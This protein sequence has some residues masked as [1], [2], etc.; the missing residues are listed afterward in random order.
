MFFDGRRIVYL[1][2]YEDSQKGVS[3]G[4]ARFLKE[5]N[6][7]KLEVNLSKVSGWKDGEYQIFLKG[8]DRDICLGFIRITEGKGTALRELSVKKDKLCYRTDEEEADKLYG[9]AVC[10]SGSKSICGYWKEPEVPLKAAGEEIAE[11]KTECEQVEHYSADKWKQLCK[12]FPKVHPFGDTREFILIEPK[13]FIILRSDYQKLV[14]NSFLLHGF[15]NYRH[16]ILGSE[17]GLGN[18]RSFYL[19]VPGVFYEREKMVA[20]MFGFEG[21]ECSGPVENGKFG[22]YMR[23]VEL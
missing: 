9:I 4:F 3:A 19:G 14:N 17:S 8:Y 11:V 10:G 23:S 16:I 2:C 21:F 20:V 22:Y 1:N 6:H 13:D 5:G 18:V 7:C 12:V 15:Y